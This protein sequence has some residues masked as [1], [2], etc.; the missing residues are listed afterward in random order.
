MRA[1]FI[2][3]CVLFGISAKAQQQ[4]V[5]QSNHSQQI[6]ATVL[7]AK[8]NVLVTH[9]SMDKTLKFW[10]EKNGLLYK[11]IDLS[12][13][14]T[15]LEIN[16]KSGIVYT[17]GN[18][19]ITTYST[20]TFQ[21]LK[22]YPL[23]R[24]YSIAYFEQAGKG[25][26]T[27]LAQDQNYMIALY[28]LDEI[29]GTF[30]P[31]N[32]QPLPFEAQQLFFEYSA[33][34]NYLYLAPDYGRYYVYS[35]ATQ[36]YTALEG[37]YIMMFDN[38]DVLRAVYRQEDKRLVYMRMNPTTRSILWNQTFTYEK[39]VE[40]IIAP[41]RFDA[42][43]SKDRKGVWLQ[44]YVLPLT[45]IDAETGAVKGSFS[46]LEE[47]YGLIDAGQYIYGQMGYEAP[48]TKHRLFEAN[49]ILQYGN[50]VI[51]PRDIIGFQNGEAIELVFSAQYGSQTFSLMAHPRVTQFTKY[52][53]TYRDEYGY[54]EMIADPTSDKVF[55][56]TT[57]ADPIKVFHRGKPESFNDLID[58]Y[59][60]AQYADFS[61]TTKLLALLYTS[62]LRVVNTETKAEVFY[63]PLDLDIGAFRKGMSLSPVNNSVAYTSREIQG[64]Q[65]MYDKLHYFDF[66]SNTEK[67]SKEGRYFGIF[68][69]KNGKELL[70]SNATSN[71][72]EIL[73]TQTGALLRSI[74]TSFDGTL[75]DSFMSPNEEL[76]LYSGYTTGESVFHIPSGKQLQ[77]FNLGN[78]SKLF[79]DFITDN[80]LAYAESGALKFMDVTTQEEVLRMYVF[81]D[82]SWIAYTPSGQFDGSQKGWEKVAF[83]KQK[84]LIPLESVFDQ[85]YTPRLVHQV[86]AQSSFK[87]NANINK[88]A[89]PPVVSLT[90]K[91]GSRNLYVTDDDTSPTE[92]NTENGTGT[93][94]LSGVAKGNAIKELRLY[95]N[96][97]R[98]GSGA[99]N[100]VVED[101]VPSDPGKRE[102][103]IKLVEGANEFSA[104]AINAQGTESAPEKLLVQYTP[105]NQQILQPQGIQAHIMVVGIDEYQNPKYNLNYAVAD[106]SS[107]QETVSRGLKD[108]TTKTHLYFIKNTDAVR[109][110]IL[111][112]LTEIA[113]AAN[114]QDIFVFYYA[115]HG[116]IASEGDQQFYL[117]PSDVT[118]L[119]GND[120]ALAQ[121]GISAEE[122]TLIASGIPAQKQL[123]I[124]DACQSA[125]ALTSLTARGAAEE[126]AIAQLARSTGT[127]WLTASGSQQFATEF[128]ELGHGVFTYVLLEALSGKADSGDKR[129]TVNELKAY[130]ES[131]VPE[132]SEQYKGSPQYPSSFG[133]G[134]DF[135]VSISKN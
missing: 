53:P 54:G 81:E 90:Y 3:W 24:I 2:L 107:F 118:Q 10:N 93:L 80:I 110:T 37:D 70:V 34:G 38:G 1:V 129:I 35:F 112:Q 17:L 61:P 68:H 15:E 75:M 125:G 5:V 7:D 92:I 82:D 133:F 132:I 60:N 88:L 12:D 78:F 42:M 33:D 14:I 99:R 65:P 16:E 26:L 74:P 76:L 96:G 43:Y 127:H 48:L 71:Q 121:K 59:R 105:A 21:K 69:L 28:A 104:I 57:T 36:E 84:E 29:T 87:S 6:T 9:G 111:D 130:I 23:G 115:G 50:K 95:H 13:N 51:E 108:I 11:T 40:G 109:G 49:P 8:R 19:V 20:E 64:D 79:G 117:V 119:Y 114:P 91:E 135:P 25:Q 67:W 113:S 39:E 62:G 131:R 85:F 120:G 22:E 123:Y 56:I 32:M 73:D 134:Q 106:A 128:D 55:G 47:T 83:L 101:D 31:A 72:I 122:L 45:L 126:K 94:L 4:F 63:K 30:L 18:N 46:E 124:L 103:A 89:S 98:V 27:L 102:F 116:V 97:K 86:L 44:N 58:N 77:V 66:G 52:Q 41:T 100:L